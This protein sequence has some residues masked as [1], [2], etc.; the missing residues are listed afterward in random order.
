MGSAVPVNPHVFSSSYSAWN[1]CYSR[2][3]SLSPLAFHLLESEQG[4]EWKPAGSPLLAPVEG[5]ETIERGGEEPKG[6]AGLLPTKDLSP[7]CPSTNPFSLAPL[8]CP[9]PPGSTHFDARG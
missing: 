1:G 2:S 5:G 6:G 9:D 3:L 7:S 8:P 4:I